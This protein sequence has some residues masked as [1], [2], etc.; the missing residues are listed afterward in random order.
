MVPAHL[1]ILTRPIIVW[2]DYFYGY[3]VCFVRSRWLVICLLRNYYWWQSQIMPPMSCFCVFII[4]H[5][6]WCLLRTLFGF[7]DLEIVWF[8]CFGLLR[9]GWSIDCR[10]R[11]HHSIKVRLCYLWVL[12]RICPADL[13]IF[14]PFFIDPWLVI[15]TR[16]F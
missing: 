15:I 6:I 9:Y 3:S 11:C 4:T 10:N 13:L 16:Q 12:Y 1:S 14:A 7:G 2:I 5:R 8:A